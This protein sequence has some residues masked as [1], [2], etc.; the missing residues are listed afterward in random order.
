MDGFEVLETM[1]ARPEWRGIPVV[2]V[3]AKDLTEADHRRL[4]G[5]VESVLHKTERSRDA[6]LAEVRDLVAAGVASR[7]HGSAG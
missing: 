2:I 3:T 5:S 6:L 7:P 4:N 1:R